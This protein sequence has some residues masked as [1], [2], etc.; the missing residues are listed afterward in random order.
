MS[1][2]WSLLEG[3]FVSPC[4]CAII[5]D[6]SCVDNYIYCYI[7]HGDADNNCNDRYMLTIIVIHT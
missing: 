1:T 7:L 5:Y 4:E 2:L 3:P 6:C